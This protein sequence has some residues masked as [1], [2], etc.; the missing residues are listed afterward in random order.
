MKILT[1]ALLTALAPA[2]PAAPEQEPTPKASDTYT[3]ECSLSNPGY[4]GYCI[5]SEQAP[6][7]LSPPAA[8]QRVLSCLNNSQCSKTYCNS[9]TVRGGWKVESAKRK[10]AK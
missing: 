5:V 7:R 3:V 4:S 1:L 2:V 10:Q 6:H 8:C 9:T